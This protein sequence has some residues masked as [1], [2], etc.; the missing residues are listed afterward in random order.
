MITVAILINGNPLMARS[1]SNTG[2]EDSKG[3]TVYACDDGSAIYH[4]DEDG[5]VALA[6]KLMDT[7]VED[8]ALKVIDDL[9]TLKKI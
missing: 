9:E 1:A 4:H 7:I 6:K 3:R 2:R 8:A 5:A